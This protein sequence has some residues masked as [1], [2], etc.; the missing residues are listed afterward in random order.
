MPSCACYLRQVPDPGFLFL[1]MLTNAL[2][3]LINLRNV[4]I[5]AMSEG[6]VPVLRILQCTS[7]RLRGLSLK[8]VV[9]TF[10]FPYTEVDTFAFPRPDLPIVLEISLS[11]IFDTSPILRTLSTHFLEL[12][13]LY[14]PSSTKTVQHYTLSHSLIHSLPLSGSFPPLL[15]LSEISPV[16]FSWATSHS[17]VMLSQ[18]F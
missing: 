10:V 5:S 4:H 12:L 15:F 3:K 18:I 11:L 1:G 13:L 9:P 17:Q 14:T 8:L 2:P 7:P 6:M 16:F